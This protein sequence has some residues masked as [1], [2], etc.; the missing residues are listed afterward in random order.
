MSKEDFCFTESWH[1]KGECGSLLW[2]TWNLGSLLK[3][4]IKKEVSISK[5][6]NEGWPNISF[7]FYLSDI[8]TYGISTH[9]Q[10]ITCHG[11]EL[12]RVDISKHLWWITI[13]FKLLLLLDLQLSHLNCLFYNF[14]A[15]EFKISAPTYH[16]AC[17]KISTSGWL[18]LRE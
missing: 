6:W 16:P 10:F 5:L 9:Y 1:I 18:V 13:S 11:L 3:I 8:F 14:S 4:I 15:T 2:R 7:I 17:A 12:L